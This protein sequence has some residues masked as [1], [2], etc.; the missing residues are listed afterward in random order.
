[1]SMLIKTGTQRITITEGSTDTIIGI[2]SEALPEFKEAMTRAMNTWQS[3]S[4]EF[5]QFYDRLRGM[6]EITKGNM[7]KEFSK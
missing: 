6:E 7:Y 1:M 2:P 5:R 4:P 3:P